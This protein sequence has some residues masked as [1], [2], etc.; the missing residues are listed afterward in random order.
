[1]CGHGPARRLG[2]VR[3][4]RLRAADLAR[5]EEVVGELAG[6]RAGGGERL[7][8]AQVQ[9]RPARGG[10]LVVEG[11]AHERVAEGE[12]VDPVGVLAH[13]ARPQGLLER[14][15]Q[16]L[17]RPP[18]HRRERAQPELAAED[19]GGGER[20]HGVGR[21]PREAPRDEVLD[22]GGQARR[23]LRRLG[24]A[25]QHLLDE[26][27]VAGGAFLQR[28]GECG[29]ADEDGG[30]GLA[31]PRER[32][33]LH[34]L[35]AAE[36]GQQPHGRA[37]EVGLGVAQ[38]HQHQQRRAVQAADDMT[39]Q[40]QRRLPGP[41]EVLDHEQQRPRRRR[42]P[43]QPGD[44]LE[45]P[46]AA[47][48]ALPG[49]PLGHLG[50]SP[51]LGHERGERRAVRRGRA[52]RVRG[53]VAQ[54]LHERL[55]GHHGLL[56]DAPVQHGRPARVG[57]R[58]KAGRQP[59]LAHPGLPG[60]DDDAA[61]RIPALAQHGQLRLAADERPLLEP[62]EDERERDRRARGR[63]GRHRRLGREQPLVERGDLRRRGRPEL[64]AQQPAQ[65]VVDAQRLGDVAARRE[66]LHQHAVGRFAVGLARDQRAR[67][68][69]GGRE[70][71]R[72]EPQRGTRE[73]LEPIRVKRLQLAAALLDPASGQLG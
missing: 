50:I 48:L 22:A 32:D 6:R 21:E 25:A 54:R 2:A 73:R 47:V 27:R 45:Q 44:R 35:L 4:G 26:E 59:R 20:L 14:R 19:G 46:V 68:A 15:Q 11:L 13:D 57:G 65:A 49:R 29:V 72:A 43:E 52:D 38:G 5:G 66:R 34:D 7:A 23:L 24:E 70:L 69:L 63:R 42:L 18:G 1:V 56:V 16:L 62:L 12:V 9:A 51:E 61:L 10:G 30:L 40:Q 64:V 39:E 53:V 60:E 71:A 36:V 31:E 8:R 67:R 28:A 33:P 41:L 17:P 3:D 55:V 37:A 58:G